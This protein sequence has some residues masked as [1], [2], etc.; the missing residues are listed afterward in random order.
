MA[1]V[2]PAPSAAP[3]DQP[4]LAAAGRDLQA[5]FT[6]CFETR[7]GTQQMRIDAILRLL[8]GRRVVARACLTNGEPVLLKLFLG[9]DAERYCQRER[10][11]YEALAAAHLPTPELLDSGATALC[12]RWLTDAVA[13]AD[14]DTARI[15]AIVELVGRLHRAELLQTDMHLDNFMAAPV[16]AAAHKEVLFALDPDGMRSAGKLSAQP[17]RYFDNLAVLFAQLP[18]V[19]DL[20]LPQRLL[21]YLHGANVAT[22]SGLARQLG[23]VLPLAVERARA[24][25]VRRYLDKTL[26]DCTEFHVEHLPAA[27][28]ACARAA[29]GPQLAAFAEDPEAVLA[30]AVVIK[31]GNT[32]TVMRVTIDGVSRI[33][34]RYNIKS[35]WH[36]LRQ[37]LRPQSRGERSWRNG[38]CLRFLRIPTAAPI[39]LLERRQRGLR[40]LVYLITEDLGQLDLATELAQQP[41]SD[42]RLQQIAALFQ[43][44]RMARLC[45]GDTKATNWLV[46][47][48]ALYLIDLD[49]MRPGGSNARDLARFLENW[50]ESA[51]VSARLRARL[52][53]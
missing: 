7:R 24:Q 17:Q 11:G 40:G 36:Q 12:Y 21:R 53:G 33:V 52:L 28:F 15:E 34:K 20:Q 23:R 46:H 39:A 51:A 27:R 4:A 48:D 26:R 37:S 49:S 3:M 43:A 13:I 5:P 42:R 25:R 6:V 9:K 31:A 38:H 8:P 2:T 32:A 29:L 50:P 35:P 22:D 1:V 30:N 14:D 41:L 10:D 47:D 19:Q 16:D 45:H 44:L 18:P